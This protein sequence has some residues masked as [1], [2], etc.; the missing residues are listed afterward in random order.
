V[1]NILVRT[2]TGA[3]LKLVPFVAKG[4]FCAVLFITGNIRVIV[5]CSG[6]GAGGK[7]ILRCRSKTGFFTTGTC[8]SN[9]T[10]VAGVRVGRLK[11]NTSSTIPKIDATTA[12]LIIPTVAIEV[13][14]AD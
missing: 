6:A 5:S 4:F 14:G 7:D 12:P 10:R 1:R 2:G 3:N 9:T 8:S 13:D 11:I